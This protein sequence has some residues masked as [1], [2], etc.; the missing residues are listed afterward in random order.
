MLRELKV[1]CTEDEDQDV[2][3][4]CNLFFPGPTLPEAFK[5]PD[6]SGDCFIFNGEV[7]TTTE[8]QRLRE[9]CESEPKGTDDCLPF[10]T[11]VK[12]NASARLTACAISSLTQQGPH[13]PRVRTTRSVDQ[14]IV[15]Q[16]MSELTIKLQQSII[17]NSEESSIVLEESDLGSVWAPPDDLIGEY[18]VEF[19]RILVEGIA[20]PNYNYCN[21][22]TGF[23]RG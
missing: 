16:K 17:S 9:L 1:F 15:S 7:Y 23:C 13:A 6:T 18:T 8:T 5:H 3:E 4:I 10:K 20:S 14:T 12:A 19:L 2:L 21:S 22:Y 11:L